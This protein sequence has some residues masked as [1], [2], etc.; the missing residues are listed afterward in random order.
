MRFLV[1]FFWGGGSVKQRGLSAQTRERGILRA[2]LGNATQ[3]STPHCCSFYFQHCPLYGC[4]FFMRVRTWCW[5]LFLD[6]SCVHTAT[7]FFFFFS[8]LFSKRYFQVLKYEV[9]QYYV[10][11]NDY[12]PD[13][14]FMMCGPRVYTLFLY[15]NDVPEGGGTKFPKVGI[16]V[17]P[18]RGRAVLWPS[19]LDETPML[20]D[21][22]TVHSA[23]PVLKGQKFGANA[24]L[25]QYDFKGPNFKGCTG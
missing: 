16:E 10:T 17:T 1:S 14:Q 9:G 12:I 8:F 18:K 21:R 11:H 20:I 3:Y 7:V 13:H 23:E 19:V 6:C 4:R 25:H 5:L 15:L 22:R 2:R 24:W